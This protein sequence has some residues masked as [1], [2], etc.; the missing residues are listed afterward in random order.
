MY[1]YIIPARRSLSSNKAG[2]SSTHSIPARPPA[3]PK[4]RQ[5]LFFSTYLTAWQPLPSAPRCV[6]RTTY[7][8]NIYCLFCKGTYI[9]PRCLAYTPCRRSY[10]SCA[11]GR[12]IR[13]RIAFGT[14]FVSCLYIPCRRSLSLADTCNRPTTRKALKA[15][16]QMLS[17]AKM[18]HY[19]NGFVLSSFQILLFD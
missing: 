7:R 9:T 4:I 1:N 2:K 11:T 17:V 14:Q 10:I 19:S 16:A 3:T 18:P 8:A 13:C 15:T 6:P 5:S 12:A